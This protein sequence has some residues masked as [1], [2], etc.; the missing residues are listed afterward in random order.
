[1]SQP[2]EQ[3][4]DV[5]DMK[6]FTALKAKAQQERDARIRAM[7]AEGLSINTIRE[8]IGVSRETVRKIAKSLRSP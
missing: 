5:K 6:E 1:M 8:R 7:C 4:Q 2:Y 3:R